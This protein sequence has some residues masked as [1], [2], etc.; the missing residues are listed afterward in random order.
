MGTILISGSITT[1][2]VFLYQER[3]LLIKMLQKIRIKQIIIYNEDDKFI[4]KIGKIEISYKLNEQT[5]NEKFEIYF[6]FPQKN[7]SVNINVNTGY[8]ELNSLVLKY[9]ASSFNFPGVNR[10]R[11]Q[12]IYLPFLF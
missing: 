4:Q 3:L 8:Y 12:L 5:P 9:R 1:V 10:L 11:Y 6:I 7:Q 2:S